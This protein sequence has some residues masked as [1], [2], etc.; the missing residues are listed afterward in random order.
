MSRQHIE[1]CQRIAYRICRY[2]I[3]SKCR[4][5]TQQQD[6]PKL[7]KA[8]LHSVWNSDIKDFLNQIKIKLPGDLPLEID[9]TL[10]IKNQYHND[11]SS[12]DPGKGSCN[13]RTGHADFRSIDQD[14]IS[15]K[16]DQIHDNGNPHGRSGIIHSPKQGCAGIVDGKR[17]D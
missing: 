14:G 6:F 9:Q 13:C 3:G 5:Q 4:Y 16:I 2:G 12:Y 15:R 7:E 10:W 17:T 11:K 1:A 8:V